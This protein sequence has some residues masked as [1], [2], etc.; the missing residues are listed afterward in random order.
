ME[1]VAYSWPVPLNFRLN[2]WPFQLPFVE[3]LTSPLAVGVKA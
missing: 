3:P 2:A 1:G